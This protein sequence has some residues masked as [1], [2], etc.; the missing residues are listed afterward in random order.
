M[1]S[2]CSNVD[3]PTCSRTSIVGNGGIGKSKPNV[4]RPSNSARSYRRNS[5]SCP[6]REPP[7]A[8]CHRQQR[9]DGGPGSPAAGGD[10]GSPADL[11]RGLAELAADDWELAVPEHHYS[12]GQIGGVLALLLQCR[13][14]LR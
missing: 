3:T 2:S 12:L 7:A 1:N 11:E 9:P 4:G 13:G 14:S 5:S 6:T 10:A 8:S